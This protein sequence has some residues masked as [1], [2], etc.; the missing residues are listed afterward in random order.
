MFPIATDYYFASKPVAAVAP[1][2]DDSR[3]INFVRLCLAATILCVSL[4]SPH[5]TYG[6]GLG[7]YL[8]L[9]GYLGYSLALYT[10]ILSYDRFAD[11][12]RNWSH[13]LDLG[14]FLSLS[15]LS[16]NLGGACYGLLFFAILVAAFR[17]GF[18]TGMRVVGVAVVLFTIMGAAAAGAIAPTDLT[19]LLLR[20]VYLLMLGYMIAC[21]GEFEVT[22][23]RRLAFV[24]DVIAP[25]NPRFGTHQTI[26][27]MLARTRT[28]FAADSCVLLS[29][30][31]AS[32]TYTLHRAD[33]DDPS[34]SARVQLITAE[35]AQAL[36]ALPADCAAVRNGPP[37]FWP[38]GAVACAAFNQITGAPVPDARQT[39]A[40]LADLLDT[41]SFIT[42]SL[43]SL[44]GVYSRVFLTARQHTFS[45]ADLN[46]LHRLVNQVLPVIENVRLLDRLASESA[47]QERQKISHDLHDS[48]LQTFVGIKL[49]L[50][51]LAR[52]LGAGGVHS[53]DLDQLIALTGDAMSDV[54]L[55][56]AELQQ[57]PEMD[58]PILLSAVRSQAAKFTELHGIEVAVLADEPLVLHDRLAAELFQMIRE[59]LS[60]IR[61]HTTARHAAISLRCQDGNVWLQI[62]NDCASSPTVRPHFIPRSISERT[63]A[64]GGQIA[65][66][67]RADGYTTVQ[68]SIPL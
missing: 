26:A 38:R 39:C 42:V 40:V 6:Q 28:F 50:E 45:E 11:T 16:S 24:K 37:G 41:E 2:F 22:I 65:V 68:I 54:R 19:W 30:H 64:L 1:E 17:W 57:R 25:A 18:S 21:W 35:M 66:T 44:D 55:Y 48:T 9:T 56:A 32:D 52:K 51:A 60:N 61:R 67:H 7:F 34:A 29:Y 14:W 33:E 62:E 46:F 13:W 53:T 5:E 8:T 43:H 12:A 23:K 10:T 47:G 15:W 58:A 59:G 20:P 49:G 63:T 31:A 36:L 3:M 27:A 4:I